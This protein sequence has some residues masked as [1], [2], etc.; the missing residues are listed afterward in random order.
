MCN[1]IML[2]RGGKVREVLNMM[3]CEYAGIRCVCVVYGV[4]KAFVVVL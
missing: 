2:V 3:S 1:G 4:R